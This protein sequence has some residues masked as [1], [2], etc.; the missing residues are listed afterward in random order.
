MYLYIL[1]C[2]PLMFILI[3]IPLAIIIAFGSAILAV[4]AAIKASEGQIY[5]YPLTLRLVK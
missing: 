4:I 1:C 2:V 3:G 5:H